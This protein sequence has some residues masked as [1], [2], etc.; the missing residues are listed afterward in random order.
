MGSGQFHEVLVEEF[1]S[2]MREPE[3]KL[4]AEVTKGTALKNLCFSN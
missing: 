1:D 3:R 4:P 2:G